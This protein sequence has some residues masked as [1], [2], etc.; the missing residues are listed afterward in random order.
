MFLAEASGWAW[1]PATLSF[2]HE[3]FA[4][5]CSGGACLGEV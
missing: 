3:D 4:Q 2:V 1:L 5:I